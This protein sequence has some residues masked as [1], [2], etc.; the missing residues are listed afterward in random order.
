MGKREQSPDKIGVGKFFAWQS[1]AL[2]SA[3]CIVILGF[4]RIYCTDQLGLSASALGLMLLLA[5]IFDAVTDLTAGYLVDR[6]K[7]KL[8]KGRPYEICIIG[9]WLCTWLMFSCPTSLAEP[10]KYAWVFITFIFVNSIFNTLLNA[11]QTPYMVRVFNKGQLVRV[12]SYGGLVTM[13]CSM[14]VS[15][16]FPILMGMLA[17][18]AKGWSTLLAIYAVPLALIGIL[19]FIFI[20]EEINIQETSKEKVSVKLI[21]KVLSKNPFIWM[22][23]LAQMLQGTIVNMGVGT[24]FYT[25]VVGNVGIMGLIMALNV[26]VLPAM[27]VVP[28][29]LKKMPKGKLILCGTI[30]QIIGALGMSAAGANIPMI[31]VA[32]L[33]GGVGVLP[34]TFLVDLQILDCCAYNEWKGLPRLEGSLASFRNFVN[35]C[36]NGIG[37]LLFGVMLDMS[38]YV[39][40]AAAQPESA[41]IMIRLAIGVVPAIMYIVIFILMFR[42]GKLDCLMPQIEKDNQATLDK[43][44][45]VN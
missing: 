41:I 19:R 39:G 7:S 26:V 37:G 45:E 36:G 30:L 3:C 16:S 38:G 25:Y 18:S 22:V 23:A 33:I 13:V 31:I 11:A 29:L 4:Q 6:T 43:M 35:K 14:V 34:L 40:T 44:A 2:S 5:N 21:F 10:I 27:F 1:R 28:I 32:S 42:Y 12:A 20:K 9:V 24:Y 17:T 15:I 8:G